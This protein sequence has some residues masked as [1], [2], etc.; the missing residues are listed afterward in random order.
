MISANWLHA[1]A[2]GRGAQLTEKPCCRAAPN[3]W[4]RLA[5]M[6][7]RGHLYHL[8]AMLH[9][10]EVLHSVAS[11]AFILVFDLKTRVPSGSVAQELLRCCID[12]SHELGTKFGMLKIAG[13]SD[14]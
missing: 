7:M 8:T 1:G 4:L 3:E 12:L 5:G 11:V 10:P 13:S 14:S 2:S 9:S 6:T